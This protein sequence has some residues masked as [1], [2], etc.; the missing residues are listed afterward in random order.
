MLIGIDIGGMSIKSGVVDKNGN[1]LFSDNE[2]TI[3]EN[4]PDY[5][6][7]SLYI[8]IDKCIEFS[9]N[10]NIEIAGIGIGVP[11]IVNNK[12]NTIIYTANLK[13]ENLNLGE[14]LSKYNLPI[15]LSNDANCAVLA[16]Q[17][18]G[19][20]K[21][22]NDVIMLTLGTGV[23]GGVIINNKLFEGNCG[24]GTEL[25]HMIIELDGE[26]C[27]CGRKGCFEAYASAS[28]LIKM[29]KDIMLKNNDSKMWT[30]CFN[31]IKNVSGRTAFECA[32]DGD[33]AAIEVV[34]KYIKYLGE[35]IMN[36]CN[37]F[38]PEAIILGG[39]ISNQKDYLKN[40]VVDYISKRNYGF[41]RS[42]KVEILIAKLGS[43]A[44]IIGAAHLL[45]RLYE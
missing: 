4:G 35:G 29:T 22:Y 38:R 33:K 6:V 16:E 8:L 2:K 1:I 7:N 37:I 34:N 32:K 21:G 20:G 42:Q 30:Y 19:S 11:G 17:K 43:E 15:C 25:G 10:N 27:G 5:F 41:K 31:S 26:E 3:V 36:F 44:G 28:G 24:Q 45:D 40:L 12:E 39:G 18:F 9:K 13:I 14:K 23:G